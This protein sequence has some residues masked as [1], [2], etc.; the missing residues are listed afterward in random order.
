MTTRMEKYHGDV[1]EQTGKLSAEDMKLLQELYDRQEALEEQVAQL[2]RKKS[3]S[4]SRFLTWGIVIECILLIG[5]LWFAFS[6]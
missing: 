1:S 5:I 3:R 4:I 2:P 6:K